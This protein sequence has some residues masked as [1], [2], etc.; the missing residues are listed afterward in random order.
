VTR[1]AEILNLV[2]SNSDLLV[3]HRL[4]RKTS[5]VTRRSL[6]TF[7]GKYT[8]Y[9]CLISNTVLIQ[10]RAITFLIVTFLSQL[11]GVVV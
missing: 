11:S 5:I 10:Y 7:F 1:C 2:R 3:D 8:L 4:Y 6:S 9:L